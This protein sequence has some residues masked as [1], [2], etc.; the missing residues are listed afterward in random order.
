MIMHVASMA[1]RVMQIIEGGS[2]RSQTVTLNCPADYMYAMKMP[3]TQKWY[4]CVVWVAK[5]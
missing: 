3:S 5:S 2:L 4:S 1:T